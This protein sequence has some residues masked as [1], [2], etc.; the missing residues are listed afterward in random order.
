M[1]TNNKN[2]TSQEDSDFNKKGY[3]ISIKE[4]EIT[5]IIVSKSWGKIE[6]IKDLMEEIRRYWID[7]KDKAKVLVDLG[8]APHIPSSLYRKTVVNLVKETIKEIGFNKVALCGGALTQ[9]MVASFIIRAI[10]LRNIKYF[11]TEEEAL[12]WLKEE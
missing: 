11:K 4:G 3:K 9:R 10:G 8:L 5:Q 6:N 1:D 2:N 7:K 12:K